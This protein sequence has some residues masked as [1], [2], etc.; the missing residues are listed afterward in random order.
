L[1]QLENFENTLAGKS[2]QVFYKT[3]ERTTISILTL[4]YLFELSAISAA[5]DNTIYFTILFHDR[6][7]VRDWSRVLDVEWNL[8]KNAQRI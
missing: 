4:A 3:A 8:S 6:P 5:S 2:L 1:G 7:I